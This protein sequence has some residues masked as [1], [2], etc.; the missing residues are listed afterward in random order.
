MSDDGFYVGY[1][2]APGRHTRFLRAAVPGFAMTLVVL[3]GVIATG[4][5]DPGLGMWESGEARTW[6]GTFVAHPY[7]MLLGDDGQTYLLAET[8]KRGPRAGLKVFE[9]DHVT[10]MGWALHREGHRMIELEP[11]G[12]AVSV[13]DDPGQPL[14]SIRPGNTVELVGEI[15]DAKCYLGAMK[16]GEGK[17]HKACATHCVAGGIPPMLY[18]REPGSRP[19]C[20]LLLGPDAGPAND[21]VLPYLGEHVRVR[22]KAGTLG[23]LDVLLLE[24]DSVRRP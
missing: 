24:G 17:A 19:R 16:P 10:I 2:P 1:L 3:A 14:P 11:T 8:G 20:V 21:L 18:T 6:N 22:G 7:P 12:A 13:L 15:L 9:G 23:G 5:R 4:Q